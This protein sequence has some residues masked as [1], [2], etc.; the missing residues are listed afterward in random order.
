MTAQQVYSICGMCTMRCPITAEVKNDEVQLLQGNPYIP[1]M[2][3]SICPK[4]AAGIALLHDNE[5][6]QAPMIR[7][8]RRGQGKWRQVSWDDA[9]EEIASRLKAVI[10]KHG[11]RSVAF[12]DRGGPFRDLHQAFVRGL[13]SPNYTNH[14][15]SCARNVHHACMSVTGVGR[16]ELVYDYKNARHV[17]LQ[18]RNIFEAINVQEVTNLIAAMEAGCK[19][20]VI[21]IRAT[22][23]ATKADRFFLVRPGSDYAFNLAVIHELLF[24]KLY[25]SEYAARWIKDLGQLVEF[26]RP[27]SP[28]WAEKETG[29]PAQE[30]RCFVREITA[31][32]PAVLWHPGYM[33][34]RYTDSFYVSRSAY[35]INA[36]LGSIGAKG[37]LLFA[38][39]PS[40][41]GKKGLNKIADLYP[42]PSEKRVDGVGWLYKHFDDGAGLAHLVYNA[43]ET[44]EP[45]P[46]KAFIAYRH[47]PL[48]AYP[49]PERLRQ[50][51]DHLDL[52]ISVSFTW[53]DTAWYSDVVLPLSTY[54]ERESIVACKNGLRPY[55]FVRQR[56][57]QPRYDTKA[58]WE[59]ICGLAKCLGMKELAFDSIEDIWNYQLKGTGVQ[60]Q[61]FNATGFVNLAESVEYPLSTDLKFQ[62]TSGKIEIISEKLEK[63]GLPS[64]KPYTPPER[65]PK[66]QFR[67]TFGRCAVHTQGHT[68]N[69][70]MLFELMPENVLWINNKAAAALNIVDGERVTVSRNGYSETIRAKVTPLIHPEAVFVVHGFGHRLPVESRAF[71]KG[72]A[73]NRFMQG[74]LKKWDPAGGGIA[75]QEHFVTVSKS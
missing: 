57:V 10:Q 75:M 51:F 18:T 6:I 50:I 26:V 38:K 37:G 72:L 33:T 4:G 55:F 31:A 65:P 58:D 27:Y 39:K 70:P 15:S 7:E 60:P 69:N 56:A 68:V 30:L 29:V 13:G 35:I 8:G 17:V 46:I 36:L 3:G 32:K 63:Q 25:D 20:T 67:L 45:Y 16:E 66:G 22:T 43:M 42:K 48:M 21:D 59:I 23:S 19:L 11:A 47:D 71:G 28:E 64:L 14:D 41:V 73:D 44:G 54:L 74:G 62:T 53:S 49:D 12:S 40:D 2:K 34:A 52:L 1:A 61:D 9:F 5:R 24:E